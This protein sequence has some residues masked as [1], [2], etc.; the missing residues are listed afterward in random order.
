MSVA[1][2]YPLIIQGGMG[3]GVSSWRLANAVSRTGQLGVVSGSM[4]DTV[5]IRRLQDG[6]PGGHVRR[7]AE[8]FP[9]PG[10]AERIIGGISARLVGR[11]EH[12]INCCRCTAGE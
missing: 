9:L 7:A 4:L 1:N 12:R 5:M 3:V 8:H 11:R 2:T 6:D 10:V